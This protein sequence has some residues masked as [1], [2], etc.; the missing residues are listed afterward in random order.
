VKPETESSTEALLKFYSRFASAKKDNP[1]RWGREL[2][3]DLQKTGQNGDAHL[4]AAQ[5]VDSLVNA[6]E[7]GD[8][9]E[10]LN[11]AKADAPRL[12]ARWEMRPEQMKDL[13][14]PAEAIWERLGY[15]QEEIDEMRALNLAED[16]AGAG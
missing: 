5:T 7:N 2:A 4:M 8:R 15:S 16:L 9:A 6:L 13:G 14:I 12:A 10:V 3:E 11:Q 1:E